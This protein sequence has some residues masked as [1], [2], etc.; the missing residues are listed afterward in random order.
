MSNL[1]STMGSRLKEFITKIC[2]EIGP[3][4]GTS[5]EEKLAGI[6]IEQE[7][8][9]YCSSTFQEEFSCHPAAF[10]DV[11]RVSVVVYIIGLFFY[12]IAPIITAI[13]GALALLLFAA[14]MMVLKEVVDPLF[15]KKKGINVYGK[16][17][18]K[19]LT[20]QIVLVSGHQDSAYEFPLHE[21]LGSKF[22]P[23]SF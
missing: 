23:S 11:V 13:F 14:E 18:P 19:E 22:S 21:R 20:K 1:D 8:K 16:I 10:L 3:R 15:P 17:F 9:Q 6:K 12:L 7:Y 5:K 4:L 2:D